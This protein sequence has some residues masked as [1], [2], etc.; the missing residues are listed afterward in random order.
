MTP[1]SINIDSIFLWFKHHYL[2]VTG[3]EELFNM[4]EATAMLKRSIAAPTCRF[5]HPD[6]NMLD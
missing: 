2:V 6:L 1:N 4:A 5:T 3:Y